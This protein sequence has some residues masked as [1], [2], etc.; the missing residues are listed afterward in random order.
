MVMRWGAGRWLKVS[1]RFHLAHSKEKERD[2]VDGCLPGKVLDLLS[3]II[4][5]P[6]V[7]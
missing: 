3:K 2:L 7:F 4:G 6:P 5:L 1:A